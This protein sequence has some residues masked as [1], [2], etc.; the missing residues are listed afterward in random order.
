[1]I[2]FLT[3]S[4]IHGNVNRAMIDSQMKETIL[5]QINGLTSINNVLLLFKLWPE[6][7]SYWDHNDSKTTQQYEKC[8]K[9]GHNNKQF[10]KTRYQNKDK[11]EKLVLSLLMYVKL[12]F[13]IWSRW[14]HKAGGRLI[15]DEIWSHKIGGC[16]TQAI[17]IW[18]VLRREFKTEVDTIQVIA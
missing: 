12:S 1:M 9:L 13:L 15:Q 10:L 4:L 11:L 3:G 6:A 17:L 16:L 14:S 5:N 7:C 18:N 2:N 8:H